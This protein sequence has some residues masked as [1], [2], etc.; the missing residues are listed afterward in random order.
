MIRT[1]FQ[2]FFLAG[3]IYGVVQG[4]F[5]AVVQ[6]VYAGRKQL[7]IVGKVLR[8]LGLAVESENERLVKSCANRALQKTRG[9]SLLKI[10]AVVHRTA[11]VKQQSKMHRQVSFPVEINNRLRRLVVVENCEVVLIE[12]ADEFAVLVRRDE[13]HIDFIYPRAN[14]DN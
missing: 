4:R 9:G 5:A 10:K 3:V 11:H 12:I 1:V 14:R 7:H 8:K 2:E 6:L 13:E